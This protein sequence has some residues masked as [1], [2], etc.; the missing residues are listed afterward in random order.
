MISLARAQVQQNKS[1]TITAASQGR[2]KG[3]LKQEEEPRLID[4][5]KP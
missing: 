3:L 4:D 5:E 1:E 2:L